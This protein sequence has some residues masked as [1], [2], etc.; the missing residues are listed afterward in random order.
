MFDQLL[1][2][3]ATLLP[4]L[5]DSTE[6]TNLRQLLGALRAE[7]GNFSE[8]VIHI[9]EGEGAAAGENAA[10]RLLFTIRVPLSFLLSE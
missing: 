6:G 10:Q 7:N 8:N 9:L 3:P 5:S 2:D 1:E 4:I